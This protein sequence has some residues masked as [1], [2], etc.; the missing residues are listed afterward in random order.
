MYIEDDRDTAEA[1]KLI[2]GVVGCEV[3]LAYTGIDGLN[4]LSKNKYDLVIF[5]IMLPDMSGMEVFEE[6]TKLGKNKDC[7]YAFLSILHVPLE[8]RKEFQEKGVVDYIT[9]PFGRDDLI[10]RVGNILSVEN[11]KEA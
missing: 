6:V 5:D 2:L 4:K 7:K 3:D 8:K 1:V 10:K 11:K 9:K